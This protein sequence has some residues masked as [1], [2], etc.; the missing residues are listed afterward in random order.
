MTVFGDN[1]YGQIT[2][3]PNRLL[4]FTA[5]INRR[6]DRFVALAFQADGRWAF[7][8]TNYTDFPTAVTNIISGQRDYL[9]SLDMLE[10][11]KVA[12]LPSSGTT[13][14]QVVD[15]VADVEDADA[16]SIVENN[17]TNVGIPYRYDKTASS[18]I[19]D[20][21]PNYSATSGLRVVYKRGAYY[22]VSTDTTRQPGFPSVFHEYLSLGASL[23]YAMDR[24]M[25]DLIATLGPRVQKME[26]DIENYFSLRNRDEKQGMTPARECNR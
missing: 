18:I 8:D 7:D 13:L 26:M 10:I 1:G 2:G 16:N 9:F 6:Q 22:F 3:N 21:T 25:K 15:K 20:P 24:T 19:L 17:S 4:Q 5:R 23:D 12:I 11:D 14:Y